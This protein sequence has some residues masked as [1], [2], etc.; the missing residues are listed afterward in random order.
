MGRG[1]SRPRRYI[2]PG[3]DA[4]VWVSSGRWGPRRARVEQCVT[5][6]AELVYH[7]WLC[8]G[9][10]MKPGARATASWRPHNSGPKWMISLEVLPNA[11]WRHGRLFFKCPRCGNRATRLYVPLEGVEPRCRRCWG[12]S[13][14]SQSWSYKPT[15]LLGR[16]LGPIAYATTLE[17]RRQRR[18]A[19]RA[20][21]AERHA[22]DIAATSASS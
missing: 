20:R 10:S 22:R 8:D 17:R 16:W 3:D 4:K 21:Y 6:A 15:G 18:R 9:V 2:T 14:E 19:S 13:Y 5:L 7:E 1:G 11:V 12:L